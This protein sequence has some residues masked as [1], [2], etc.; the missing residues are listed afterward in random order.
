MDVST[1]LSQSVP[2]SPSLS[3][4]KSVLYVCVSFAALLIGYQYHLSRFHIYALTYDIFLFDLLH[5]V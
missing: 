1:L 5:S 4:Q 2:P 3:V